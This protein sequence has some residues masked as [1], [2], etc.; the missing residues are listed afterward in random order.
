MKNDN[1][2]KIEELLVD[3][4]DCVLS[5][6]DTTLVR[7]HLDGCQDCRDTVKALEES[8]TMAQLIWNDNLAE[9]AVR[10][11]RTAAR[12]YIQIAAGLLFVI[13]IFF[14]YHAKDKTTTAPPEI[15]V[16]S[17]LPTL[18]E[19]LLQIETE[20]IAARVLARAELIQQNPDRIPNSAKHVQNEYR[21]IVRMYPE[22]ATAKKAAKLI[23]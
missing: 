16:A 14:A 22:T 7:K 13:G 5:K 21:H 8:L 3:F 4:A 19:I 18:D 17:T 10:H 11:R 23:H 12:K 6:Q 2:D 20:G 1:C 15:A 9:P